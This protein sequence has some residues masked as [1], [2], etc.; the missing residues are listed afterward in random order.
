[1]PRLAGSEK[2][3]RPTREDGPLPS[4]RSFATREAEL[5]FLVE[6]VRT[7]HAE[8]VPHEEMAILY[9][10]NARS[11]EYEEELAAAGIPY[12]VRGA[13]FLS[14]PAAKRLPRALENVDS[15]EV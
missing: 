1:V 8:G 7:L 10:L 9:R 6:R 14:R 2:V 12:Q 11:E 3:L 4:P 13:A 15:R 5:A